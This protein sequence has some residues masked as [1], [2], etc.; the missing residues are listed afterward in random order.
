MLLISANQPLLFYCFPLFSVFNFIDICSY[1]YY[2][3]LSAFF[4]F[5]LFLF[6]HLES[7]Y[8]PLSNEVMGSL[9]YQYLAC[10]QIKS[11]AP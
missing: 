3:L 7:I 6:S 1:L 4:V 2:F 5:I 8:S 10:I 9:I 11:D